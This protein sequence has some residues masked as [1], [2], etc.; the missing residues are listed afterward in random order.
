[1]KKITLVTEQNGSF[2]TKTP[3]RKGF[4]IHKISNNRYLNFEI[5]RLEHLHL[6]TADQRVS[7]NN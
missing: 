5:V 6:L 3:Y 7:S 4:E 1:M 2:L